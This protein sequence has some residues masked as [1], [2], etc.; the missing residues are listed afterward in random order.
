MFIFKDLKLSACKGREQQYIFLYCVFVFGFDI[1]CKLNVIYASAHYLITFD[2]GIEKPVFRILFFCLFFFSSALTLIFWA[3]F[4][5]KI[6]ISVFPKRNHQKIAWK[7]NL[8]RIFTHMLIVRVAKQSPLERT[9][10]SKAQMSTY[11][12][13]C[14]SV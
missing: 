1:S 8:K 4:F 11:L 12:I 7:K 3:I 14:H 13:R 10:K 9:V 6:Q 5:F 2:D